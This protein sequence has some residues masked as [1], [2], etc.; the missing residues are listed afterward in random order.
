MKSYTASHTLEHE[1]VTWLEIPAPSSILLTSE[2]IHEISAPQTRFY[3]PAQRGLTTKPAAN[4]EN[5][6][7]NPPTETMK[8][9]LVLWA[10][11]LAAGRQVLHLYLPAVRHWRMCDLDSRSTQPPPSRSQR[12]QTRWDRSSDLNF[13]SMDW[14]RK[15]KKTF[16]GKRWKKDQACKDGEAVGWCAC[17]MN[18]SRGVKHASLGSI[19]TTILKDLVFIINMNRRRSR[20]N[21]SPSKKRKHVHQAFPNAKTAL[22]KEQRLTKPSLYID[23]GRLDPQRCRWPR[24]GFLSERNSMLRLGPS[25]EKVL[26][27]SRPKI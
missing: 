12:C 3:D 14:E 10:F 5:L 19:W 16:L 17:I 21:P 18:N 23:I 22:A 13:S 25:L 7:L 27:F 20:Q 15:K 2:K 4:G 6:F 26:Y 8:P 11:W 24:L 1:L 9:F